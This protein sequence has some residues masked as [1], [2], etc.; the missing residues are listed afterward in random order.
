CFHGHQWGTPV[1]RGRTAGAGG[2]GVRADAERGGSL[3]YGSDHGDVTWGGSAMTRWMGVGRSVDPDSRTSGAAAA[4][5]ALTGPEPKL[6][7]VFASVAHDLV[8]VQEGIADVIEG[9][10]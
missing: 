9:V 1:G 3:P 5:S 7:L 10:P 4:R 6:L 2:R 8:A